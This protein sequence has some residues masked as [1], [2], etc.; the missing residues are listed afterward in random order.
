MSRSRAWFALLLLSGLLA[1]CFPQ[2]TFLPLKTPVVSSS[3]SATLAP[4]APS[5]TLTPGVDLGVSP[6]A[7]RGLRITFWHGADGAQASALAQLSAE[8]N[9]S[10]PWGI[11]VS[12][13]GWQN[14]TGLGE[15]FRQAPA[16]GTLPDVLLALPE[17]EAAWAQEEL[18]APLSPY[19]QHPEFGLSPAE[20]AD[21]SP[22]LP[23]D[24]VSLPTLRSVRLLAYNSAWA[25]ELGYSSPPA[26]PQEFRQQACAANAVWRAD[27]DPANDGYGG[28]VI[29]PHPWTA[30]AWLRAFGGD[31]W[32]EGVFTY[33]TPA[34]R[35]TLTF[36]QA[37]RQEGCSW[38]AE[39]KVHYAALAERKA[40]FVSLNLAEL[41]EQAAAMGVTGDLWNLI[42]FPGQ[43]G[44]SYGANLALV[45]SA[46]PRQLA[47]WLFARWLVSP[48]VQARWAEK[49]GY[50]P[51]RISALQ[52]MQAYAAA[53]PQWAQAASLLPSLG[54][55]PFAPQW[56]V[57]RNLWGDAFGAI[58]LTGAEP[59]LTLS[60][61]Q[62]M[63]G[64]LSR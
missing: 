29:D 9:L 2:V 39:G 23:E 27:S 11:N 15:A 19:L 56:G 28:W 59:A 32:Q 57:A 62:S 55:P 3:P 43:A 31:V 50:L 7:L 17:Q 37:L 45:Q 63:L 13:Q 60:Q 25:Q 21:F 49:S 24:A 44:V 18:L 12:P 64:E 34:A 38:A 42:P 4:P 22:A 46:P 30:Y 61:A 33:D 58:L 53:H 1:A 48:M 6:Q 8:F 20:R 41:P 54:A 47:A 35:E 5:P 10:N 16:A 26:T 40:L 36:L 51:G 14:Y 52:E